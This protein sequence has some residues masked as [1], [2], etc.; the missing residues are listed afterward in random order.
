MSTQQA[1]SNPLSA[2]EIVSRT[3]R[4]YI[5]H[6]GRFVLAAAIFVVPSRLL[7][8]IGLGGSWLEW[9][10]GALATLA[11]TFFALAALEGAPTAG[12]GIVNDWS[13]LRTYIYASILLFLV[14][15]VTIVPGYL[16]LTQAGDTALQG[17]GLLLLLVGGPIFF[18]IMLRWSVSTPLIVKEPLGARDALKRSWALT[19]HHLWHCIAVWLL[20]WAAIGVSTIVLGVFTSFLGGVLE[21]ILDAVTTVLLWPL[22]AIAAVLLYLD[23]N[24]RQLTTAASKEGVVSIPAAA[25]SVAVAG[26]LIA[27]ANTLREQGDAWTAIAEYD[28]AIQADP[29]SAAGFYGRGLAYADAGMAGSAVE[30]FERAIAIEPA[31]PAY[32]LEWALASEHSGATSHAVDGFKKVVELSQDATLCERAEQ[33][34]ARLGVVS[35]SGDGHVPTGEVPDSAGMTQEPAVDAETPVGDG[36]IP[37]GDDPVSVSSN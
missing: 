23:L 27:G 35:A 3:F 16:L 34:L 19:G 29:H 37:A 2:G 36:Q 32:Y 4:L 33:G 7:S 21:T 26:A 9:G 28:S 12:W 24:I 22:S 6:F 30:D 1:I 14:A 31:N 13:R 11:I 5:T 17:A 8:G 25:S 10:L 20:V 15:L 18:Y